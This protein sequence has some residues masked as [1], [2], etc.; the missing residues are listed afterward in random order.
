M[1]QN[2]VSNAQPD[3]SIIRTILFW[4]T[5][6]DKLDWQKQKKAII[7]RVFERGNDIEKTKITRFSRYVI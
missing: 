4:D 6:I 2:I 1:K 7:K 3:L 5:K